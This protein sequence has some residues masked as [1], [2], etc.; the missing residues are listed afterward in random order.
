MKKFL[1]YLIAVTMMN[2]MAYGWEDDVSKNTQI[3]PTGLTYIENDVKTNKNGMTYV[4]MMCGGADISMRLQIVDPNGERLLSRGGQII[5]E[6]PNRSWFGFNQYMELDKDGNV[7]I[8]VQDYRNHVEEE[9]LTY[10]IYKYD[11]SGN[12]LLDGITLNDGIGHALETGL[13]MCATDDG[14]CVCAYQYTD[15]EQGSDFIFVEKISNEGKSLWKKILYQS[16]NF[17]FPYPF[18]TDAGNGRVLVLITTEIGEIKAQIIKPD[19]TLEKED[20]ETVYTE[21][22]ASSKIWEA[23]QVEELPGNKTLVTIVDRRYHGRMLVINGDGSIGLDGSN[24]G[25]Q[26]SGDYYASGTPAI[27]YNEQDDTYTCAFKMFDIDYSAYQSMWLQKYSGKDGNA[28]W[29]E[30]KELVAFQTDYQYGYYVMRNAG[31]GRSA[32]FYMKMDNSNYNDVKAYMQV[33][34]SDG[35]ILSD[36]V[37]FTTAAS[38]KQT[39][40]VSELTD[41]Q[42]VAAW[43]DKRNSQMSL[44]MQNIKFDGTTG[45]SCPETI[46]AGKDV[47]T[48]YFS[49]DGRK[50]NSLQKGLNI[51]KTTDG[52]TVKTVKIIK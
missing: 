52:N 4:F 33:I 31:D 17:T 8:G 25:V 42:F 19:G 51:I 32:L 36:P 43:D 26:V 47:K 5:S 48:E 45:I 50:L 34:E 44:F 6:E 22:F 15:E 12:K 41:G 13:S 14:G 35:S 37:P 1:L 24:T 2:N 40:R 18:V 38:S 3:T 9:K 49:S 27:A 28:I 16:E 20:F 10:T 39:L 23:M 46:T 11:Q 21:G 7:F 29:D 30:P